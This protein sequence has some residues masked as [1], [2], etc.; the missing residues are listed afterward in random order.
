MN[1]KSLILG[2]AAALVAGGAAQA[3]DLPVAEPVDYVKVCDAYGAGYFFIPG[4][5]TCLKISGYAR[6]EATF[7]EG[8]RATQKFD[9]W[10]RG[11]VNFEAKEETEFGTLSSHVRFEGDVGKGE[12]GNIDLKRAYMTLG[13][14]YAGYLT[15]AGIVDYA[16]D[17]YGGDYDL[18]DT[19]AGQIGYNMALGNGV[20]ATLGIANNK[21]LGDVNGILPGN[22]FAGQTLP[23]LVA[24]LKVDQAWGSVSVGGLV[25]QARY[26]SAI[27]DNEVAYS[28]AAGG[29]FNL[30]MLSEGSNLA[31]NG[32][33]TKG[34]MAWNG[35]G[36]STYMSDASMDGTDYEL[37]ELYGVSASLK[38]AFADNLWAI[39]AGG[40]G[41][42][43]DKGTTDYD[44]DFYTVSGEVG[45]KPVKNLKIIAGIQYTDRDFDYATSADT[46]VWEGKLRLQR[47]F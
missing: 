41:E 22:G 4:T 30:D 28:V 32:F 34:A 23:T 27:Y 19:E 25:S 46:E 38:Y 13:G 37:N 26:D 45:Y 11:Q 31:L 9:L 24:R 2:S 36:N 29:L 47:D 17:M 7:N 15:T 44:Y 21:H 8:D 43:D 12:D 16:G 10:A 1:I 42:Y 40:Y 5:D 3:A 39:V 20:T 6:T 35:V 18:G 14:F 33:Y